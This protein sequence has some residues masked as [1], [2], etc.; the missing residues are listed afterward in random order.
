MFEAILFA[1]MKGLLGS[2]EVVAGEIEELLDTM[3]D[4]EEDLKTGDPTIID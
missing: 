2:K 4:W 1:D 3:I